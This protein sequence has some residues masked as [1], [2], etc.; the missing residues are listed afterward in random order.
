MSSNMPCYLVC[1]DSDHCILKREAM[2]TALDAGE[3]TV[4]AGAATEADASV[5]TDEGLVA[6]MAGWNAR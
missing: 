3:V 4:L 1:F 6:L 2:S 5:D